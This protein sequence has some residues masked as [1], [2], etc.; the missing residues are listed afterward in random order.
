MK[1]RSSRGGAAGTC[2]VWR[3][4]GLPRYCSPFPQPTTRLSDSS[5]ERRSGDGERE[6]RNQRKVES[7]AEREKHGG[8]GGGEDRR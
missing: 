2:Q 5:P 1:E 4:A 3:R 7:E 8:I 6:A